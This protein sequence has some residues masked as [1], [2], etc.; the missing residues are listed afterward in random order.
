MSETTHGDGEKMEQ[1]AL[2]DALKAVQDVQKAQGRNQE[3][4]RVMAQILSQLQE[5][6]SADPT[7]K[8]QERLLK[9]YLLQIK[10]TEKMELP[11]ISE[12]RARAIHTLAQAML[13]TH[14]GASL[15]MIQAVKTSF[16]EKQQYFVQAIL[17]SLFEQGQDDKML[18]RRVG[19]YPS[20]IRLWATGLEL[21]S[22]KKQKQLWEAYLATCVLSRP[23]TIAP[24]V[25]VQILEEPLMPSTLV[26]AVT[27]L[28]E[29]ATKGWLLSQGRFAD[30]LEYT[31]TRD[32]RFVREAGVTV[33]KLSHNSP[34]NID[35]TLSASN[36]A[37]ATTTMIDGIAQVRSRQALKELEIQ[38]Q[39]QALKRLEQQREHEQEQ[40]VLEREKQ[41]L[42]LETQRLEII[43]KQLEVQKKA[44]EYSLELAGTYVDTLQPDLD[45]AARAMAMQA[46]LPSILQL[47][48][49]T[50]LAVLL[51][52]QQKK[53][54]SEVSHENTQDN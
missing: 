13:Q 7:A 30:L 20:T 37:E 18:A 46:V 36:V 33:G 9:N 40:A 1:A 21:P 39:V 2:L 48:N 32:G 42:V 53:G 23:S 54:A 12:Q 17:R 45:P 19:V 47:Q 27:A 14:E 16:L 52:E 38:A 34:L 6:W 43:E 41:R 51:P 22:E 3:T 31:Q 49:I 35:I 28:I 25:R 24:T 50:G 5:S 29:L 4:D 44:V 15:K 8:A 10:K 26:M 11:Q